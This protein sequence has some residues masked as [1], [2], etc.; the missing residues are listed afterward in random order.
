MTDQIHDRLIYRGYEHIIYAVSGN[1]PLTPEE[2]GIRPIFMSTACSRGYYMVYGCDNNNVY[3]KEM[4]VHTENDIYPEIDGFYRFRGV[5]DIW[6]TMTYTGWKAITSF[7]GGLIIGRDLRRGGGTVYMS[8][9]KTCKTII[10][11][12]FN[13]GILEKESD[14]SDKMEHNVNVST[15]DIDEELS[16]KYDFRYPD[17]LA[18]YK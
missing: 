11:L 18:H 9:W 8:Y 10:E 16:L 17:T 1:G 7:T 4:T 15:N 12:T 6:T 2:L 14:H 13:N 5:N 3:L